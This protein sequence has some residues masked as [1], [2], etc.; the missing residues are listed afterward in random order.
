M[1]RELIT[2]QKETSVEEV[3]RLIVENNI[4]AVPVVEEGERLVGVV[5]EADLIYKKMFP[6]A[7]ALIY[8]YGS[9]F[10]P[11]AYQEEE[12]KIRATRAAEAMSTSVITVRETTPVEKI[13]R[14]MEEKKIKRVFVTSEDKLVGVVSKLDILRC[15][16]GPCE[17]A[18]RKVRALPSRAEKVSDVMTSPVFS[19]FP[20]EPL[21]KVVKVLL[22]NRIS[23]LP[24]INEK[25]EV[26]GVI[27]ESDL[28]HWAKEH[29]PSLNYWRER[30]HFLKGVKALAARKASDIM[31]SPAIT[32]E[33]DAT[34]EEA[35]ALLS[36]K[37][38][39]RLPVEREGQLVGIVTRSDIV[40]GILAWKS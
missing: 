34:L 18:V 12:K 30:E 13:I 23:G 25:E 31:T 14:I 20:D 36:E 24:V 8:H 35:A 26:I 6:S 33:E 38:V 40:K 3:A 39:K 10:S 15:L 11:E 1:T 17:E 37:K 32:V 19:V 22:D 2:A 4:S 5:S 29:T 7:M 21:E 9:Y 28:I 16:S 27:S